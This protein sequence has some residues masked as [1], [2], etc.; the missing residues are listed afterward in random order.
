MFTFFGLFADPLS[1]LSERISRTWPGFNV[2]RMER[3]IQ[4]IAARFGADAYEHELEDIPEAVIR[5]VEIVSAEYPDARFLL[6]RTECF[7]AICGNWGQVIQNGKTVFQ[8]EGDGALRNLIKYWGVD[9]GPS[10]IFDPLRRDYPWTSVN[11]EP[12]R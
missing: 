6:L 1:G 9:L 7:G 3:P 12:R 4:A 11:P 5:A 8:A 2:I 10:E